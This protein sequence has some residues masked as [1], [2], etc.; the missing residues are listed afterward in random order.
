MP[1]SRRAE[2][3]DG[4]LP[5]Y[6]DLEPGSGVGPARIMNATYWPFQSY[7]ELGALPSALPSARLHARFVVAEWG[8]EPI[9]DTVEL[10]VSELVTN[11][12]KASREL[13]HLPPVWLGLSGDADRVLIAV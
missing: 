2:V 12:V 4:S 1:P 7:L 13:E 8:L 3:V 6:S 11:G 5:P 10:V 9:V